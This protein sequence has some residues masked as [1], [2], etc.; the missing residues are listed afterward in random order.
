MNKSLFAVFA[1]DRYPHQAAVALGPGMKLK[2][3]YRAPAP[4]HADAVREFLE[5][6]IKALGLELPDAP[7]RAGRQAEK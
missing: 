7:A 5:T 3:S 4:A 1:E 6:E 2:L